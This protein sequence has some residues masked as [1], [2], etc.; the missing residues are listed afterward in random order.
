MVYC[1]GASVWGLG[2]PQ[3]LLPWLR[4]G[5]GCQW[6]EDRW[7][8]GDL[9]G[10]KE[11][12]TVH[13]SVYI[14][15]WVK[16]PTSWTERIMSPNINFLSEIVSPNPNSLFWKPIEYSKPRLPDLKVKVVQ[17][18]NFL[19]ESGISPNPNFL[20]WK[21]ESPYLSHYHWRNV[22]IIF[23]KSVLVFRL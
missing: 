6:G 23:L 16:I 1:T 22:T 2:C 14:P 11:I 5:G 12:Y 8:L 20:I 17:T 15:V 21:R 3:H 13:C 7:T 4:W 9:Q 10:N 18:L 19:T